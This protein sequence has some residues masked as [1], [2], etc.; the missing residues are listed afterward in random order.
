MN[1]ADPF[2][3]RQAAGRDDVEVEV[4]EQIVNDW[5][6]LAAQS[7]RDIY[8]SIYGD[9]LVATKHYSA[10]A[11]TFG[12]TIVLTDDYL[13]SHVRHLMGQRF[14]ISDPV[15]SWRAFQRQHLTWLVAAGP[16]DATTRA[17]PISPLETRRVLLDDEVENT[18]DEAY[19]FPESPAPTKYLNVRLQVTEAPPAMTLNLDDD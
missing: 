9:F 5:S 17:I 10:E 8:T 11:W 13:G 15:M 12:A 1:R 16:S 2:E 18:E 19:E 14:V 3:W 4:R 6:M 7:D